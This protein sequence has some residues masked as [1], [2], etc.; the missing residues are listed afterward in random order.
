VFAR[1]E[2]PRI[3]TGARHWLKDEASDYFRSQGAT[4]PYQQ[5]KTI[6]QIVR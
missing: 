3:Q 2:K 5:D 4:S 6:E 1:I